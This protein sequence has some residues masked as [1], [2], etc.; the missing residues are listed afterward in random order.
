MPKGTLF[1]IVGPSGAGKDTLVNM[2]LQRR[3]DLYLMP[4]TITRPTVDGGHISVSAEEYAALKR[5][6]EFA[7][8]WDAHGSRYAIGRDIQDRLANGQSVLVIGS[9]SIVD[10]ARSKFHPL[11]VIQLVAKLDILSRR[12]RQRDR[13]TEDDIDHR[14]GRAD[15]SGPNGADVTTI[16]NSGTLE[17]GLALML[18]ALE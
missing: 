17:E 14:L 9:R 3:T 13:E 6:Y 10:E 18:A 7:L 12:L 5:N 11:K 1:L 4:R 15:R 8:S 16:D 2:V